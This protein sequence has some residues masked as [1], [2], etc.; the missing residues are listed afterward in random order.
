MVLLFYRVTHRIPTFT[1]HDLTNNN[2]RG[3]GQAGRIF[4]QIA[5]APS[6][7]DTDYNQQGADPPSIV[8]G[9]MIPFR[10]RVLPS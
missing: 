2:I 7:T 8:K 9:H 1:S 10:D 4:V 6:Q 5:N 3:V